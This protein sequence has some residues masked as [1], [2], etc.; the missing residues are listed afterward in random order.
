MKQLTQRHGIL[1]G[2]DVIV[3]ALMT[4]WGFA[5]HH[6]LETAGWYMLTTFLPVLIAWL[7]IAPFFGVYDLDKIAHLRQIW[8]PFYAM[9]VISPMAAF[10]RS[11]WLGRGI[12]PLFIFV[13]GGFSAIGILFWRTIYWVLFSRGK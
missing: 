1:I 13:L 10:L 7:M 11:L 9:V 3:A 2:G 6:T 12:A 8:R 4:L 5:T